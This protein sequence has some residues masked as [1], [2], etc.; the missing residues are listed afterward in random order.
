MTLGTGQS[1]ATLV[2]CILR[3]GST[4]TQADTWSSRSRLADVDGA[5]T[6][7]GPLRGCNL[8]PRRRN[9]CCIRV[10]LVHRLEGRDQQIS[11]GAFRVREDLTAQ[12]TAGALHKTL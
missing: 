11:E 4:R 7:E 6:L 8:L 10:P 2:T 1:D 3:D 12:R 5:L 9:G